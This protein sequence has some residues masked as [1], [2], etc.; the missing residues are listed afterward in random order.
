MANNVSEIRMT[1]NIFPGK[2]VSK[3]LSATAET[4]FE[5]PKLITDKLEDIVKPV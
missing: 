2:T 5:H 4:F 3:I 1:I